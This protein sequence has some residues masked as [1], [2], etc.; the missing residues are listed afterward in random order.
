MNTMTLYTNP[1]SRGRVVRWMLEEVG[2]PYS[3]EVMEFGGSI[4]SPEYL[5][6]NPMG[7]VPTLTHKG[8]VITETVAICTY[9]AE[10]FPDSGL[11]PALDSPARA[12]YYRWLFFA[13]GPFEMATSAKAYKWPIDDECAVAIGCGHIEDAINTLEKTLTAQPY[14][15]GDSFTTADLVMSSYLGWEMMMKNIDPR[16]A[17]TA[18]VERCEGREAARRANRLDDALMEESA[19]S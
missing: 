14:L 3:V 5:K 8:A 15:C 10:Q 12:S 4:K 18:Y 17:F 13:A 7:K 11:A 19:V 16:P 1:Q 9:L 6:L 2:Q